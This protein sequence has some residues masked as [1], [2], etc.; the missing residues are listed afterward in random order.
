MVIA[1]PTTPKVVTQDDIRGFL[2]DVAGQVAGTGVANY[3]LDGVEFSDED[4]QRALRYTVARFNVMTPPSRDSE[5]SINPWLLL[6]GV[7][8]FLM[9][10]ESFR[11]GRNQ[12]T[13]QD[14][15]ISPIGIDDKQQQ[16]LQMSQILKSEFEEK[17]KN[18]KISRNME[19]A[20]GSLGSGYRAVSRFYPK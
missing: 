6:V 19:A 7:S 14:G 11:Q 8:E 2:R 1:T 10:S 4:I 12:A 5:N 16:Y 9:L 20:Y 13:Y 18:W 15:N 3:L 17:A